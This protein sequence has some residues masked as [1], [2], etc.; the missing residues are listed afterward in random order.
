MKILL[1]EDEA[2][3]RESIISYF[4]GEGNICEAAVDFNS[5]L[6]LITDKAFERFLCFVP[7]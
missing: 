4:T 1:I 5:A 2:S 3:L 7:F 6:D